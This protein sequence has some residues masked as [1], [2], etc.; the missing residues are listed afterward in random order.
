MGTIFK[1]REEV[2]GWRSA[3]PAMQI[4]TALSP[5]WIMP[6][7]RASTPLGS[8][9]STREPP[10]L[11]HHKT[12]ALN[13]E[14]KGAGDQWSRRARDQ[15]TRRPKDQGTSGPEDQGTSGPKDQR[16]RAPKDQGT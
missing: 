12:S 7:Q 3:S 14:T 2:R 13:Q 16:A 6:Y 1:E 9:L 15:Q 11:K 4:W 10:R 8:Y 5:H